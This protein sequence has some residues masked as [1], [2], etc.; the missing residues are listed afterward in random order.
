MAK[1]LTHKEA[2]RIFKES[3]AY[4]VFVARGTFNQWV[5]YGEFKTSSNYPI[6][7]LA[8]TKGKVSVFLKSGGTN[9]IRMTGMM[10]DEMNELIIKVQRLQTAINNYG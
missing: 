1:R 6:L 5:T 7:Q 2:N 3:G 10:L 9:T 4:R 8:Y